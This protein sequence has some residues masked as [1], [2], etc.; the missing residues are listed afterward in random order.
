M[1][2]DPIKNLQWNKGGR[3]PTDNK[4]G[5]PTPN[6]GSD[7]D[8]QIKQTTLGAR[9]FGKIGGRW[10]HTP[11]AVDDKVRFGTA[12]SDQLVITNESLSV[13]KDRT[14]VAKFSQDTIITGGTVTIRNTTN[15]NDKVVL[16]ENSLKVYDNNTEV[17]SFG[18]FLIRT[19]G[20]LAFGESILNVSVSLKISPAASKVISPSAAISK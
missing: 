19:K 17:A 13:F 11:L 2:R 10:Y 3:P 14:E 4:I 5:F 12:Q 8:I 16:A 15:N 7:G 18:V 9:L 20:S 6:S 1:A